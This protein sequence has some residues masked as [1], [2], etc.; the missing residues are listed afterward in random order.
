MRNFDYA[1]DNF[2]SK[3]DHCTLRTYKKRKLK[4]LREF[5]IYNVSLSAFDK[6]TNEIQ[7]DNI[8]HSLIM[9]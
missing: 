5:G 2:T 3:T 4:L 8:A 9:G 7:V 1:T 6:A